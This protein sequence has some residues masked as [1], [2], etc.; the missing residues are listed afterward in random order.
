MGQ[1]RGSHELFQ[2]L[3]FISWLMC[4]ILNCVSLQMFWLRGQVRYPS[5]APRGV[6]YARPDIT[7]TVDG[8]SNT[9]L[10][11]YVLYARPDITVTVDWTSNTKLL[12]YVFYAR[13]DITVTVDWTSNTKLLTYVLY[14][15]GNRME[16]EG[17]GKSG[18][19]NEKPGPPPGLFTQLLWSQWN[20]S[21]GKCAFFNCL[22]GSLNQQ[23]H[24]DCAS[25]S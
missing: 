12:T 22:S 4:W 23:S 18:T 19:G 21:V 6:L 24:N 20:I 9:K 11:T 17:R 10:L 16:Y 3:V 5:L 8:T 1:L 2:T 13:P 7:V 15:H 25:C 14:V